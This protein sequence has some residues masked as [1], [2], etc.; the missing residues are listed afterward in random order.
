MKKLSLFLL[1][2]VFLSVVSSAYAHPPSDIK[3]TFD[4][5]AKILTAVIMHNTSNTINHYI[6]KVDVGLNGKDIIE[7]TIS[8]Q[9]NNE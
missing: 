6:N 5:I 9:D 2:I 7:Q 1:F 4:P 8:K 3:I